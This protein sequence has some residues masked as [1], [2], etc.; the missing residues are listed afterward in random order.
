MIDDLGITD[1]DN[2]TIDLAGH[3]HCNQCRS[4][5]GRDDRVGRTLLELAKACNEHSCD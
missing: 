1:L 3:V 5:I 4:R 2:F